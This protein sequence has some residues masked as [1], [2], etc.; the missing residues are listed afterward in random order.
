MLLKL[1]PGFSLLP[2]T[3][4]AHPCPL[5]VLLRAVPCTPGYALTLLLSSPVLLLHRNAPGLLPG[6]V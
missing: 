2:R 5:Q 6:L 3:P 4:K 1:L